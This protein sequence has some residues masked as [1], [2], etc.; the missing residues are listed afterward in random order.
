MHASVFDALRKLA[1]D[2]AGIA[3]RENKET[4]VSA[5]IAKRMRKFGFQS[6]GQYL[7]YLRGDSSGEEMVQFLDAI[8]T[9]FTSFFREPD[10]FALLKDECQEWARR[11]ATNVRIW[12]AAAATGE[13]PYTLAMTLAE[14]LD[15]RGVGWKLLASDISVRALQSA[16]A[17]VYDSSRLAQVPTQLR[18]RYFEPEMANAAGESTSRVVESLRSRVMFKRLNLSTPPFPMRGDLDAVFCRNVMIYFDNAVRQRLI[19]EI[20]RLLR[21]GGLL[22]VAHSETLNGI[23]S[24]LKTVRPSVYRKPVSA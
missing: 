4:L 23:R 24:G 6:E 8:S 7:D 22:V 21:P 1:Y 17:G 3:I 15:E 14:N 18:R 2:Q 13:E 12:C 9:N 5:R 10:H 16:T 20:E 19:S 11:G